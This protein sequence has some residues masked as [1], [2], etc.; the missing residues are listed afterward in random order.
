MN[1]LYPLYLYL[2]GNVEVRSEV[3]LNHPDVIGF[4]YLNE[5]AI[6]KAFQPK[7]LSTSK[8]TK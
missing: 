6:T 4:I 3:I 7:R 1:D 5:N 8:L 2:K